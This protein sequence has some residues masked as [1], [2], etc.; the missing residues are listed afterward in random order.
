MDHLRPVLTA[1]RLSVGQHATPGCQAIF[2]RRAE[3]KK[4]HG[5]DAGAIAYLAGHHPAAAESD[6]AVEDFAFNGGVNA[7]QQ[8]ADVI[9][10]GAVFV[11]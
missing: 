10:M 1:L 6:V 11:A 9:Q 4:A 7:G 3:V 2:H 8:F 5:E